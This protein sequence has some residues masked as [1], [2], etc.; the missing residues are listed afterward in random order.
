MRV[1]YEYCQSTSTTAKHRLPRKLEWKSKRCFLPAERQTN[2][3]TV[4]RPK[5]I[6]VDYKKVAA[7]PKFPWASSKVHAAMDV[8]NSLEGPAE[9]DFSNI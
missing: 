8:E 1:L 9:R 3:L 4:F 7:F 2:S 5:H 6:E